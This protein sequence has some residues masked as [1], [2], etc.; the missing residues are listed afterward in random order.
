MAGRQRERRNKFLQHIWKK[1]GKAWH[2]AR[3]CRVTSENALLSYVQ[4]PKQAPHLHFDIKTNSFRKLPL[5]LIFLVFL[6]KSSVA[7]CLYLVCVMVAPV[8]WIMQACC[9]VGLGVQEEARGLSIARGRGDQRFP[10]GCWRVSGEGRWAACLWQSWASW[11]HHFTRE[12][13]KKQRMEKQCWGEDHDFKS[14]DVKTNNTEVCWLSPSSWLK[15]HLFK[16]DDFSKPLFTSLLELGL[17]ALSITSTGTLACRPCL[18]G[19]KRSFAALGSP[20]RLHPPPPQYPMWWEI[21]G[22]MLPQS[23]RP[24]SRRWGPAEEQCCQALLLKCCAIAVP[25]FLTR[26]LPPFPLSPKHGASALLV[27]WV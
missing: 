4:L 18:Q 19:R 3:V 22:A 9:S 2:G 13:G 12:K 16:W 11:C 17:P 27:V 21:M 7:P 25:L 5:F 6:V 23:C 10:E 14:M 1:Q 26:C 20:Q 8:S 15:L 24:C